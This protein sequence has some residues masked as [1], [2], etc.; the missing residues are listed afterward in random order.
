MPVQVFDMHLCARENII[1]KETK[2]FFQ[3]E[4]SRLHSDFDLL[5]PPTEVLHLH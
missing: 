1:L 5:T 2:S 3:C 4:W